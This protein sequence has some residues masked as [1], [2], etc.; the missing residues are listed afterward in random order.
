MICMNLHVLLWKKVKTLH[1]VAEGSK[2][3][4][5]GIR[6]DIPL[7]VV[8]ILAI[9]S[10]LLKTRLVFSKTFQNF[11]ITSEHLFIYKSGKKV[12]SATS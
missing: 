9:F 1:I 3:A 12:K 2:Y 10:S 5:V 4:F 7:D 6:Q 11:F 8:K